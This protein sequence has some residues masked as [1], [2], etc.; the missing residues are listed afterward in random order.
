[1]ASIRERNGKFCVIYHYMDADGKRRQKW[2]TYKTRGE[3]NRR[4]KAV[5]FKENQG[6]FVVS[7][8][9]RLKDTSTRGSLKSIIR[10]SRRRLQ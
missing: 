1:M 5:E 4:K 9:T 8:C 10:N 3:A 7:Q 2:E 6:A